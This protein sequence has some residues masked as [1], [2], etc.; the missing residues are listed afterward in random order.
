[1][2]YSKITLLVKKQR[3]TKAELAGLFGIT[4]NGLSKKFNKGTLTVVELEKVSDFLKVPVS[5]FFEDK[6]HS[7]QEPEKTYKTCK[8]CLKKDTL[9]EELRRE[10]KIQKEDIAMLNRELGR[11]YPNERAK[12]G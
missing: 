8:E 7:V 3:I 11:N 2:D 4:Y 10:N 6:P 1:M 12:V 9:I 5:Y